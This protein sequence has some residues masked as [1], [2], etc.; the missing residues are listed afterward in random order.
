MGPLVRNLLPSLSVLI[1][2]STFINNAVA[3]GATDAAIIRLDPTGVEPAAVQRIGDR[4]DIAL[5]TATGLSVLPHRTTVKRLESFRDSE[6]PCE[7]VRCRAALSTFLGVHLTAELRF[8]R[9][10]ASATG[11]KERW[12]ALLTLFNSITRATATQSRVCEPCTERDFLSALDELV[13]ETAKQLPGKAGDILVR[14]RPVDGELLIDREVVGRTP[15]RQSVA[16]GEHVLVVRAPGYRDS[17]PITIQVRAGEEQP[18]TITLEPAPVVSPPEKRPSSSRAA[19]FF[20]LGAASA[21]LAA[22]SIVG[23]AVEASR[24][25]DPSCGALPPGVPCSTRI[26]AT[27]GIGLA[28]AGT[29]L[30]AGTSIGVR[31]GGSIQAGSPSAA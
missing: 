27:A 17:Q 2:L 21:I 8:R 22:G 11:G 24:H 14:S 20:G 10:P 12:T 26:D 15:F 1:C 6:S 13:S 4:L 3:A 19:V 9:E 31:I 30:F 16:L 23:L 25:G 29:V 7:S 18:V 5:Q 28:V